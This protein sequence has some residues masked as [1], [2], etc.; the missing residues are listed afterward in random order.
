MKWKL[1]SVISV[2]LGLTAFSGGSVTPLVAAQAGEANAQ[3]PSTTPFPEF[4]RSAPSSDSGQSLVAASGGA[5]EHNVFHPVVP[6][7]IVDTR[8]GGG[9]I[10]TAGTTR[11]FRAIASSYADQGGAASNCGTLGVGRISAIHVNITTTGAVGGGWL[12][13]YPYGTPAPNAS[14]SNYS[15]GDDEANAMTIP[16]SY[17]SFDD[18]TIRN[19]AGTTHV[20]VDIMGYEQPEIWADV[21]SSGVVDLGSRNTSSSAFAGLPGRF[22]VVFDRVITSCRVSASHGS[23]F[24]TF[25][26]VSVDYRT[27]N[28]AAV[29]VETRASDGAFFNLSFSVRVDC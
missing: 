2:V 19:D 27:G 21:N 20:I 8:Y 26:F 13:A 28:A 6:C 4:R 10:M 24:G 9:G 23:A 5:S 7:R 12:K 11:D 1:I 25:G 29:F 18:F 16:I 22:E 15:S 3:Y 14:I 17:G